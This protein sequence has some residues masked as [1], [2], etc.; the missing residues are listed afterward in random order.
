MLRMP[1]ASSFVRSVWLSVLALSVLCAGNGVAAP[2][3]ATA[4]SP[5]KPEAKPLTLAMADQLVQGASD[6]QLRAVRVFQGPHDLY[7]VVVER[8]DKEDSI[9]VMWVTP[10]RT[11]IM[12]GTLRD[13]SGTDLNETALIA[14]GLRL[15]P[16]A[17]LRLASQM[18]S[19]PIMTKG[20]GPILTAFVDPNCIYCH[21]LYQEIMPYVLQGD[22]RVRFIMVGL[23]RPDSSDRA[24]AILSAADPSAALAEDQAK[25]DSVNEEGGYPIGGSIPLAAA[26]AAVKSN[27]SLMART[28]IDGTPAFLYCSKATKDV[29][30]MIGIPETVSL[31]VRDLAAEP[32][33][34]S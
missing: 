18:K 9:S 16:K 2:R 8:G 21:A 6:G 7:G 10:D 27:N 12:A 26:A 24:V 33:C 5:A 11:A 32:A 34:G 30:L 3:P 17:S 23:I 19:Q 1:K 28:G 20:A 4:P 31:L 29:K 14:L 25:F 13:F 22:I 15:R